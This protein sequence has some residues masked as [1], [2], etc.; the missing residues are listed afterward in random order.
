MVTSK[1]INALLVLVL[2]TNFHSLWN[3]I[4]RI[5]PFKMKPFFNTITSMHLTPEP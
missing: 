1:Q 2:V 3:F 4:L 5:E